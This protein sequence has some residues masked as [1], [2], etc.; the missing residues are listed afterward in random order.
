[1]PRLAVGAMAPASSR[2]NAPVNQ[3]RPAA[4]GPASGPASGPGAADPM[5]GIS[6]PTTR[7]DDGA[8][9]GLVKTHRIAPLLAQHAG[10]AR[11]ASN[12]AICRFREAWFTGVGEGH[13]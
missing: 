11:V 8:P 2:Y 10:R 4:T 3:V 9:R 13:E 7:P 1:M 12:W 6:H 5:P